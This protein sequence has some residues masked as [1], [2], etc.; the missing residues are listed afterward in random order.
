MAKARILVADDEPVVHD[1]LG[2]W[3]RKEAWD[4]AGAKNGAEALAQFE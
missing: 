1:M 3:F 2:L 4:V